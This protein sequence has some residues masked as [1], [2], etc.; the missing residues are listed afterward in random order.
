MPDELVPRL[1]AYLRAR[2][3]QSAVA[4]EDGATVLKF[5][6]M[7]APQQVRLRSVP[8][9]SWAVSYSVH[10]PGAKERWF[11]E[12]KGV[13]FPEHAGCRRVPFAPLDGRFKMYAADPALFADVFGNG[14]LPEAL[15]RIPEEDHLK[16]SLQDG[17]LLLA[18]DLRLDPGAADRDARLLDCADRLLRLGVQCFKSV[19]VARLSRG[20]ATKFPE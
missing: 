16:A 12:S 18:W 13:W 10:L 6:V 14:D 11:L 8:P 7:G 5:S 3:P 20:E 1:E 15:L 9:G 17:E 4:V 2:D 19:Q